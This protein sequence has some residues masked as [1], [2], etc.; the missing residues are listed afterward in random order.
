V[1]D[2]GKLFHPSLIYLTQQ[3]SLT[4]GKVSALLTFLYQLV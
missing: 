1:F 2:L 3:G 4:E